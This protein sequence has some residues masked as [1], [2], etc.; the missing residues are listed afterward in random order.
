MTDFTDPMPT[1]RLRRAVSAF[2][3]RAVA[4]STLVFTL[5][6]G[7]S[8]GAI[9]LGMAGPFQESFGLANRRGANSP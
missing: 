3:A 4:F 6:C 1:T 9:V 8:S 7:S 5:S 2:A